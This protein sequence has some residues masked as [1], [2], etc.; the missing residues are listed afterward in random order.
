MSEKKSE[1]IEVSTVS[2]SQ[3][4]GV[5]GNNV[6]RKISKTNLFA[7]IK[8]ESF[9]PFIYPSIELLQAADL[10]ADEDNPTYVRCEETEYRLYKITN[11]APSGDDI[12]LANGNTATFQVEYRDIGFVVGPA[13]SVAGSLAIFTDTG[14][15]QLDDL[16]VPTNAG[17]AFMQAADS[18]SVS[19]PRKNA[20]NTV[21]MLGAS[22][23]FDAIKQV[24]AVG[25]SG[26]IE[27]AS[28]ASTLVQTATDEAVTPANLAALKASSTEVITGTNTVKYVTPETLQDKLEADGTLVIDNVAALASTPV[29]AGAVYY[30]KEYHA[31]TGAGG[32]WL[33]GVAGST[34]YNNV[35][36]FAGSGGYFR[37]ISFG[38]FLNPLMAGA[39]GDGSTNDRTA[40]ASLFALVDEYKNFDFLNLDY[41]L[42]SISVHRNA[43]FEFVE[44]D[45]ITIKGKPNFIVTTAFA[46]PQEIKYESVLQFVDCSDLYVEAKANGQSGFNT[47]APQPNGVIAVRLVSDVTDAENVYVD[48]EVEYGVQAL[49]GDAT[50]REAGYPSWRARLPA[51]PYY[52]NIRFKAR[53]GLSKYGATF[54][55]VG[56]GVIGE[57]I[58]KGT[59]R[60]YFVTGVTNHNINI[61]SEEQRHVTDVLIKAYDDDVRNISVKLVQRGS[62]STE[63]AVA[64]EH[65][66]SAQGTTIESI[67]LDI[68]TDRATGNQ[69]MLGSIDITTGLY[70]A[71]TTTQTKNINVNWTG[72]LS[73]V[74]NS[75]IRIRSAQSITADLRINRYFEIYGQSTFGY[76]IQRGNSF[77]AMEKGGGSIRLLPDLATSSGFSALVNLRNTSDYTDVLAANRYSAIYL[78]EW[79]RL[80]G[81]TGA[82]VSSTLVS[83]TTVGA[84]PVITFSVA[85]GAL[86]IDTNRAEANSV[87]SAEMVIVGD[88]SC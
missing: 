82:V 62:T 83:S 61:V 14:G 36:L 6:D 39:R 25:Y 77:A 59:T 12:S 88:R 71:T 58:T 26:T 51:D 60:S 56:D 19:Y 5:F 63:D 45:G 33:V 84:A 4:F 32:G 48:A 29:V 8:N 68:N 31:G 66:N 79:Y 72:R 57:I 65:E 81:G 85:D 49:R 9:A 54:N 24:S 78:V 13:T 21:S 46:D 40:I 16:L 38:K 73:T 80:S 43:I 2:D 44:K 27:T 64:I 18:A 11:L 7:Q 70:R 76:T 35:T 20:D 15:A 22:T 37:R 67:N 87:L 50:W 28:D 3:Y 23:Y 34:T 42:G 86:I 30:L 10:E 47:T 52:K 41:F 1:F 74:D 75:S 17:K 69:L 55:S 53:S